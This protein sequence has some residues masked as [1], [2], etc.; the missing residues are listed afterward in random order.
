MWLR[1]VMNYQYA[2]GGSATEALRHLWAEGGVRRLYRG[3]GPALIQAPLS[4]F[5]GKLKD[6][7]L[8]AL[9][10]LETQQEM[11]PSSFCWPTPVLQLPFKLPQLPSSLLRGECSSCPSTQ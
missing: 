6:N 5:Q 1:T 8:E 2:H 9:K 11:W 4:R 3:L 10:G 7:D